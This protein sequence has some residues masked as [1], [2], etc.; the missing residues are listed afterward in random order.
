[1]D[2]KP[3]EMSDAFAL[4]E[5]DLQMEDNENWI[6]F[7]LSEEGFLKLQNVQRK[8]LVADE[9]DQRPWAFPTE[10]CKANQVPGFHLMPT[11]SIIAW[12]QHMWWWSIQSKAKEVIQNW[13][14]SFQSV[15][16]NMHFKL[17][18][19]KKKQR[20]GQALMKGNWLLEKCLLNAIGS[21]A[22][23]LQMEHFFCQ[24][25]SQLKLMLLIAM[26]E[27]TLIPCPCQL[28]TMTTR[29][30]DISWQDFQAVVMTMEFAECQ[31]WS[32]S[33]LSILAQDI[34]SLVIGPLPTALAR[35]QHS[36]HPVATLC[37]QIKS[38]STF[39]LASWESLPNTPLACWKP[40]FHFSNVFSNAFSLKLKKSKT[41][42]KES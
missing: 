26:T 2:G 21:I 29:K 8:I 7:W 1:M 20:I 22:L 33:S 38:N 15:Q 11:P 18:H 17:D 23:G 24:H 28:P 19:W 5:K 27:S 6:P 42:W 39:A 9:W 3:C 25:C 40:N 31:S 16:K 35:C 41:P 10:K 14:R 36:K 4:F 30:S 34:P 13:K 32:K 12:S 37:S